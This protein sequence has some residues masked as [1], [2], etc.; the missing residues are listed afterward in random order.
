MAWS[1][2]PLLLPVV[3]K[4]LYRNQQQVQRQ[5]QYLHRRQLRQLG[6]CSAFLHL[7]VDQQVACAI[8]CA[9]HGVYRRQMRMERPIAYALET[10]SGPLHDPE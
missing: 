4:Q 3:A 9:L 7:R 2:S 10:S 1:S 5:R 8:D 6:S